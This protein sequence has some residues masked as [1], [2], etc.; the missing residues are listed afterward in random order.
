MASVCE[1]QRCAADIE[2]ATD[3]ADLGCRGL[4]ARDTYA[5]SLLR[6]E[7]DRVPRETTAVRLTRTCGKAPDAPKVSIESLDVPQWARR[8]APSAD[9]RP[10]GRRRYPSVYV[11]TI[12]AQLI[13]GAG[14]GISAFVRLIYPL[15]SARAHGSSHRASRRRRAFTSF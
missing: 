5:P 3:H 15:Q 6:V 13:R 12:I 9:A 11:A 1:W 8:F 7:Q 2:S 4:D 14:C 10:D